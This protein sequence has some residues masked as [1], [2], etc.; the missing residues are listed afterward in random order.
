MLFIGYLYFLKQIDSIIKLSINNKNIIMN[1]SNSIHIDNLHSQSKLFSPSVINKA[2]VSITLL[3][4]FLVPWADS[5]WDGLPRLVATAAI[6]L[7][8]LQL[9]VHGSHQKYTVY[10]LSVAVYFSWQLLSMIWSPDL[11]RSE[12]VAKTTIQLLL[13]ITLFSLVIDNK[14][15]LIAAYQTYVFASIAASGIVLK[16]YINGIESGYLRYG[17]QNLTIDAVGVFLALAIPFAAYLAKYSTN[18][19]IRFIN[20]LAIPFITYGIFL[21]AT[22]TAFVAAIFG[23]MYWVY[24]Q[25]KASLKIKAV[26]LVFLTGAFVAVIAVTPTSSIERI[27]ST[28]ESISKGTLNN[29]SIIWE[30]SFSQW[31]ES[32]IIGVGLGGLGHAL[33]RER[34]NYDAA[35]NSFIHIMTENGI[36]GLTL[37]LFVHLSILYLITL[38]PNN[39]KAFLLSLLLIIIVSQLATHLQTEKIMWFVYTVLAIH[40]RLY[41]KNNKKIG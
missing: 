39:E 29:R 24:T 3:F 8:V 7:S 30:G 5:I 38:T 13:L 9:F 1:N 36:I 17:I 16:N 4:I 31:K 23:F 20:L 28:G 14:A 10:H 21:T 33:N 2:A 19:S 11:H 6:G 15:R 34:V 35:H 41:A 40:A 22:R 25:R 12:I 18:K 26:I 32:P 27:F 37:F